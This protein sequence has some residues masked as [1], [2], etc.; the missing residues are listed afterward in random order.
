[1]NRLTSCWLPCHYSLL[2]RHF[3]YGF[4]LHEQGRRRVRGIA[5]Y[6]TCYRLLAL[7]LAVL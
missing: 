3:G 1:M 4:T 5:F 2:Y 6:G 7:D